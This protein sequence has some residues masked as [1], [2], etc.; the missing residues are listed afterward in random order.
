MKTL[1]LGGGGREHALAL[2]LSTSLASG[3]LYAAPGNPG[4]AEVATLVDLDPTDGP[5]VAAWAR[6]AGIDLC[7]IGP[8]APLVAGV[9][10]ALREEGIACFG[11]SAQAARLE[12]S[13]AFAKEVMDA[14][15]VATA[16]C[17]VCVS[18]ADVAAALDR[19]GAP[20][21]VKADGLAA[22]KGVVV[23][24]E[25]EV[26]LA[27]GRACVAAGGQ[28][29]V[30]E[31]LDGPEVS[32]FCVCDGDTVVPLIPAQDFKRAFDGHRGPN[33]GGMG[34]Y[35]PLPDLDADFTDTVVREVAAPVVRE[36]A[37]RGTP[38]Q[39]LL[40]CGLALTR[41]GI[42]VVEF[43]V[44]FGDPETQVVVAL[45]GERIGELVWR[46][47]TGS[48]AE[49]ESRAEPTAG[50]AITVVL[51][52]EGYPGPLVEAGRSIRGLDAAAEVEGVHII[53]AGTAQRDG[54]IVATGGRVL[55]V[56]ATAP[57]LAAARERAYDALA[58]I[59]L[60]GAHYRTD[61]AA[62]ACARN[63]GD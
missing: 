22:G 10:D 17:E 4:I 58:A 18:E 57:T 19:F 52:N 50:A 25:R 49:A 29:V 15:G 34:A 47:A 41:A 1:I 56:V 5:A 62:D 39:G 48:L 20:H 21:V 24:D 23:T 28:V 14:A 32:L 36:M 43:N 33:T 63:R 44:R 35:A 61:I 9:A 37:R 51:A 3:E 27:H 53:H 38:F 46:A 60:E 16:A 40:Y 59:E 6:E 7:V 30:E 13:K 54:E 8:E 55:N 26:A 45:E 31:Y 2:A 11:P 42:R 12:A